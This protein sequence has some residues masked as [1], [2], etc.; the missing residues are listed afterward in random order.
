MLPLDTQGSLDKVTAAMNDAEQYTQPGENHAFL[1]RF[2]GKWTTSTRFFMGSEPTPGEPGTWEFSWLIDGR[3]LQSHGTG[4]MF[5]KPV[6][7]HSLMG[8]DAFKQTFVVTSVSSMD[9]AMNRAEGRLTPDQS[10]LI[11]YGTIDEYLTGEHDKMVKTVWR[12]PSDDQMT[13]EV[14]DLVIGE[15]NTKVLEVSFER[16]T[17]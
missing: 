16:I 4:T 12:L 1:N 9:T 14:H 3:W 6:T 11:L 17:D 10:A 8:Y 7:G 13:M 15:T 5:G 2:V